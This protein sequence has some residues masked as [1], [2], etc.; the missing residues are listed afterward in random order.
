MLVAGNAGQVDVLDGVA[1]G[2]MSQVVQKR[3]GHKDL[4]RLRADRRREPLLVGKLFQVHQGQAVDAQ[5]VLE[6]GVQRRRIDQRDQA[7][8]ADPRQAAEFRRVDELPHPRRQ[9]HVH[10]GR[11]ADHRPPRIQGRHFRNV[12]DRL[13]KDEG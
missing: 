13:H 7:Q 11:N 9:R 1:K 2:P 4:G 6:A 3:G 8:L 5:A 10:L 12:E